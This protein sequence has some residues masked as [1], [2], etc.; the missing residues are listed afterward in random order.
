MNRHY[1]EKSQVGL[2]KCAQ[3]QRERIDYAGVKRTENQ[4]WNEKSG[5]KGRTV[6]HNATL[7]DGEDWSKGFVD[8][9]FE[10]GIITSVQSVSHGLNDLDNTHVI[11]LDGAHVT[12]GLV[13]MHSHHG[14]GS[15]PVMAGNDDTNEVN[16]A[17]GPLT[18]MVRSY[19]GIKPNDPAIAIIA[20]GGVTSSLILP[21][22]AN[23]MG[24]EAVMIKNVIKGGETG[25]AMVGRDTIALWSHAM[26]KSSWYWH[27]RVLCGR[28]MV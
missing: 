4:R 20:S 22:S 3:F 15:W 23:I 16:R 6:L 21:G 25:E 14:I 11:D 26:A 19:D 24:G 5:Q 13:D 18:P 27:T 8:V 17:T 2:E 28:Y 12:P 9:V 10:K 1:I 7:F